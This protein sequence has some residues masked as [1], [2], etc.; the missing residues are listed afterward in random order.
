VASFADGRFI[1]GGHD[2]FDEVERAQIVQAEESVL[3]HMPTQER[4]LPDPGNA[5]GQPTNSH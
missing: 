2:R 5:I 3:P 1:V 4:R